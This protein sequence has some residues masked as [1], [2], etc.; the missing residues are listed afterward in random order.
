M[1][2][3]IPGTMLTLETDNYELR[4]LLAG[5]A[6]ETYVNWW[7]DPD[8]Q[9]PL[10]FKPRGW[11]KENAIKHIGR[12]DN[13]Q[14]FHIGIFPYGERLPVGFISIFQEPRNR[15]TTNIVIGNKDFWGKSVVLEVRAAILEFLFLKRDV[16]KVCGKVSARNFASIFNY[17]AQGFTCEGVLREHDIGLDGKRED[18]LMFGLLKNEWLKARTEGETS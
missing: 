12:F 5:D 1:T 11:T 7:N 3:W 15:A 2:D 18:Q 4:S 17:K 13:R 14:K 6:T 9:A 8:I 10:G 16:H